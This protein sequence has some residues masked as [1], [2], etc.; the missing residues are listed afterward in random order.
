VGLW[1]LLVFLPD[2]GGGDIGRWERGA[3]GERR[4]ALV[5]ESLPGRRWSVWHDL[6]IP[7]S[8]ANID[9]VVVGRTGVWVVDTKTT[10]AAVSRRWR[11][12]RFGER[13]LDTTALRWEASVLADMLAESGGLDGRRT[14]RAL[15][16]AVRPV[17]ALDA[18]GLDRPGRAGGVPVVATP[19]LCDRVRRG[20]RRL[21]RR[22]RQL[23]VEILEERFGPAAAGSGATGRGAH[24]D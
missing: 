2:L 21:G 19:S 8:R 12:V 23:V 24:H 10:R 7:G 14:S 18:P 15:R 5:L 17:V 22:D 6:A 9:H 11:S 4:T 13:R 16:R 1:A 20:R 3:A